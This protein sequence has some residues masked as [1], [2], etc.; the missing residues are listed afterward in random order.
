MVFYTG[1]YVYKI[2]TLKCYFHYPEKLQSEVSKC[3]VWRKVISFHSMLLIAVSYKWRGMNL[4]KTQWW[5]HYLL[6]ALVW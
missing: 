6:T 5:S 1:W 2:D 4:Q 3:E